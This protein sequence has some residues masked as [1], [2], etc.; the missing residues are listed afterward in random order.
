[1]RTEAVCR[2]ACVMSRLR[3]REGIRNE[4]VWENLQTYS[5]VLRNT[6]DRLERDREVMFLH[7]MS[8]TFDR[9]YARNVQ[10]AKL[11][12]IKH[13]IQKAT[14]QDAKLSPPG[15]DPQDGFF[16][17]RMKSFL[18]KYLRQLYNLISLTPARP[19]KRPH[20]PAICSECA[21]FLGLL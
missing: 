9:R 19:Q 4:E 7:L 8:A 6:A 12:L 15:K 20:A 16:S 13:L 14:Y 1:M 18:N 10:N 11:D 2:C 3:L 21:G 17:K 5:P